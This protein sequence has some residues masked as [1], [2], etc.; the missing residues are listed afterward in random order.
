MITNVGPATWG[1]GEQYQWFVAV[2]GNRGAKNPFT[3]RTRSVEGFYQSYHD[4]VFEWLKENKYKDPVH[5]P[6]P[7]NCVYQELP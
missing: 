4:D 3:V 6:H 5:I 2:Q 1:F 7:S